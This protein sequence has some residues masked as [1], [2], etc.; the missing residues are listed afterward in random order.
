MHLFTAL[1]LLVQVGDD[2][3]LELDPQKQHQQQLVVGMGVE[4]EVGDL[5]TSSSL[6]HHHTQHRQ[7]QGEK[8]RTG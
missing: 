4:E 2:D 6:H 5:H 8:R 1:F 3:L 7:T